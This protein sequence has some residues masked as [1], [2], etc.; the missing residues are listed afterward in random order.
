L[1]SRG[2]VIAAVVAIAVLLVGSTAFSH[3]AEAKKRQPSEIK[4]LVLNVGEIKHKLLLRVCLADDDDCFTKEKTIDLQKHSGDKRATVATY[5]LTF[6]PNPKDLFSPS[7][8]IACGKLN[9]HAQNGDDSVCSSLKKV[10]SKHWI[11]VMSY[12][13]LLK[14]SFDEGQLRFD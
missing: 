13:D 12:E 3:S 6:S 7:D 9:G 10:K 8:V 2:L 14:T 4:V 1:Y 5:H 11:A